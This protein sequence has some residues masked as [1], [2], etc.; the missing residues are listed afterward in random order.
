MAHT[1]SQL[2]NSSDGS[3]D[4]K[5]RALQ[6]LASSQ[7]N[8]FQDHNNLLSPTG[9]LPLLDLELSGDDLGPPPSHA[10]Q[11]SCL[12]VTPAEPGARG[13]LHSFLERELAANGVRIV[14]L[15]CLGH[16]LQ[17]SLSSDEVPDQDLLVPF[18][19]ERF[20][21]TQVDRQIQ[22]VEIY[23]YQEGCELPFWR[24]EFSPAD[25][26]LAMPRQR[27][28]KI[29]PIRFVFSTQSEGD[30]SN[31]SLSTQQAKDLCGAQFLDS[32]SYE[33]RVPDVFESSGSGL[34]SPPAQFGSIDLTQQAEPSAF[35]GNVQHA[36]AIDPAQSS[37]QIAQKQVVE[38]ATLAKRKLVDD[39]L[40]RYSA[41]ER[42]FAEIDLSET[43]LS[44]INLTLVDLQCAQLVWTNL[45]EASLYHVNLLGAKLR[46]ANL[47]DAKLKSANLRGTDFLNADLSGAD[48]SWSN[49]TGANLTGAN[50]TNAN[51]KNAILDNVIMPDGTRLD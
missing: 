11:E 16:R 32:D 6:A 51:L 18:I 24:S 26:E 33:R 37:A 17:L 25:I 20:M 22:K 21:D 28:A 12:L 14:E 10:A 2:P 40:G 27:P 19:Q 38:A 23:A 3:S 9:S 35:L 48:L 34:E 31:L 36:D 39:F 44:G 47:K 41:G 8:D 30:G 4:L 43:D 46:H 45:Q 5:R 7:D 49:L 42:G 29:E 15:E 1:V 13:A 50:L